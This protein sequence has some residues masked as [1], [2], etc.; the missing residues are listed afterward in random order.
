MSGTFWAFVPAI[1]AIILALISKQVY[2]SL[3]VG[4]LTGAMLLAG[5]NPLEALG[6]LY[7]AMSQKVGA[8]VPIV[9][10][11]VML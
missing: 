1:V 5:G 10:F 8:N 2:L 4:I 9:V 7:T 6:I 3:F 11:L